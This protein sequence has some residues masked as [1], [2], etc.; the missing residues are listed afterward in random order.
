MYGNANVASEE[1]NGSGYRHALSAA[2]RITERIQRGSMSEAT[3]NLILNI[4]Q[5]IEHKSRSIINDTITD[6]INRQLC[7]L[8]DILDL[9]LPKT[10]AD[11]ASD[12]T[13][14]PTIDNPR[15]TDAYST[16]HES[17]K[18]YKK[19]LLLHASAEG[20]LPEAVEAHSPPGHQ[21]APGAEAEPTRE[22]THFDADDRPDVLLD[23]PDLTVE[24]LELEVRDLHVLLKFDTEVAY[25]LVK[26]CP[27]VEVNLGSASVKLNN[28]QANALC[29]VRMDNL[30]QIVDNTLR[31]AERNP[32]AVAALRNMDTN[33]KKCDSTDQSTNTY[34]G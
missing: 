18:K 30:R 2:S 6:L 16:A 31:T 12:L 25:G 32:D 13:S 23:I 15:A 19:S 8:L 1:N 33:A 5:W 29:V 14:P 34:T 4:V 28:L 21:A 24:N 20:Q 27:F 17:T 26:I 10:I 3:K 11:N 9:L 22:R 7:A